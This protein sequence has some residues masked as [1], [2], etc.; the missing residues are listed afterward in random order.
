MSE[1]T[2]LQNEMAGADRLLVGRPFPPTVGQ[3]RNWGAMTPNFMK[4]N[5]RL[6]GSADL[7]NEFTK[8]ARTATVDG[9]ETRTTHSSP[10]NQPIHVVRK[11]ARNPH[12]KSQ[13]SNIQYHFVY[14]RAAVDPH[15]PQSDPERTGERGYR[16]RVLMDTRGGMFPGRSRFGQSAGGRTKYLYWH[17]S[18]A[19]MNWLLQ[20]SEEA[21][22]ED[23]P[24]RS[25]N[26]A[27]NEWRP[28][29]T[30]V[31]RKGDRD[32]FGKPLFTGEDAHVTVS[33]YSHSFCVNYWGD[34]AVKGATLFFIYKR[35]ERDTLPLKPNAYVLGLNEPLEIHAIPLR[36]QDGVKGSRKLGLVDKPFQIIPYA[37]VGVT[38]PP[39]SEL[40]YTDNKG[41]RKMATFHIVGIVADGSSRRV[42][43]HDAIS[44][45]I[46]DAAAHECPKIAVHLGVY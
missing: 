45:P 15:S 22:A 27:L 10:E 33:R 25:I 34:A 19:E 20:S 40:M 32:R 31:A 35:V 3:E 8:M 38:S 2:R 5:K 26:E 39:S 30:V 24:D 16:R 36:D 11:L 9:P 46:S 1:L 4:G 21:T 29:G 44:A 18:V 41:L 12:L 6:F 14:I 23:E 7:L 42:N 37:E 13:E 28:D 17:A 43:R